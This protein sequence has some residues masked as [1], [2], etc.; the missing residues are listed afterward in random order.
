MQFETV[1]IRLNKKWCLPL[2]PETKGISDERV[3]TKFAYI[4]VKTR[5]H[6]WIW[7]KQYHYQEIY[8]YAP[9]TIWPKWYKIRPMFTRSTTSSPYVLKKEN[10]CNYKISLL[11]SKT[12]L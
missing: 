9:N 3:S 12:I 7:W 6:G 5:D 1:W 8:Y 4:P 10:L 11:G 2:H